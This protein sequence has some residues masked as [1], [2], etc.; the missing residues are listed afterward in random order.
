MN[1]DGRLRVASTGHYDRYVAQLYNPLQDRLEVIKWS[2]E[3]FSDPDQVAAR[4]AGVDLF[5]LHWPDYILGENL[6]QHRRLIEVLNSAQVPIV[7]TLHDAAPQSTR[8]PSSE[9][10]SLWAAATAGAI[11]HSNWGQSEIVR[12]YDFPAGTLH[13]V[14]PHAHWGKIIFRGENL[15]RESAEQGLNLQPCALRIGVAATPR[16]AK[17][18][19][20]LLDAFAACDREDWQLLVL[21]LNDDQVP[22]DPRIAALPY[23]R[24]SRGLYNQR[25]RAIDVFA[26]PF[27]SDPSMLTTGLIAEIVALGRP[28]L[29]SDW[30]YIAEV[31][32]AAGIP[33]GSTRDDLTNCLNRLD[34]RT[35]EAAA[36]ASVCLQQQYK[37]R[38]AAEETLSFLQEV[39]EAS[40]T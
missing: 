9:M 37:P 19:Q 8:D 4:A 6:T 22:N 25:L 29:V 40:T 26:L 13:R 36:S 20:L 35:V 31:L 33:Y 32:G 5:H 23:E 24:V 14:I 7:W 28:A 15:D 38:K 18:V 17:D 2:N 21:C 34:Q 10:Y 3:I 27:R 11:H 39:Y 16:R 12:R 30:P 1:N